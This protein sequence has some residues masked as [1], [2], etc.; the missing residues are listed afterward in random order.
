MTEFMKRLKAE[1]VN[2]IKLAKA[3][4]FVVSPYGGYNEYAYVGLCIKGVV[5]LTVGMD[6]L[7][8]A[9]YEF[10]SLENGFCGFADNSRDEFYELGKSL[11]KYATKEKA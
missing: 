10:D 3:N 9:F 11:R 4:G 1:L 8:I 7:G 2:D 5:N 6:S